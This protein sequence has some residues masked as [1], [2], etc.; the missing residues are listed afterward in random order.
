M[1][2]PIR[3]SRANRVRATVTLVLALF[4]AACERSIPERVSGVAAPSNVVTATATVDVL[5]G[6]TSMPGAEQIALVE[7]VGG[8]VTHRY[9]YIPVV[10]ATIPADQRDVLAAAAGVAYI[11]DDRQL[12]LFGGKQI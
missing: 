10:A 8:R 11:E 3:R 9:K 4:V 12:I 2:S 1:R 7:S 6:F 5:V